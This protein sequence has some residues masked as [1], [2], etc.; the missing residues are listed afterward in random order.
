MDL[1]D[2]IGRLARRGIYTVADLAGLK[3]I[4][5]YSN[6]RPEEL[7]FSKLGEHNGQNDAV[8]H[9]LASAEMSKRYGPRVADFLTTAYEKGL[10]FTEPNERAYNMDIHNNQLGRELAAQY[11][12]RADLEQAVIDLM[13][14][15]HQ[16]G[17]GIQG[18]QGAGL[19]GTPRWLKESEMN[20]TY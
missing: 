8:R 15:A 7:G 16:T 18:K 11:P 19:P 9:I 17:Q 14:N 10:Y 5:D 4:K 1:Q 3:D 20:Y 13:Q 2:T 12:N 6:N